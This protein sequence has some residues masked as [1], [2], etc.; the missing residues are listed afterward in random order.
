MGLQNEGCC[1]SEVVVGSGL[2]VSNFFQHSQCKKCLVKL[3]PRKLLEQEEIDAAAASVAAAPV[4]FGAAFSAVVVVVV[5]AA[6]VVFPD[7]SFSF[8]RPS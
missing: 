8:L 7:F 5:A 1:H 4:V 3:K 2:T 6:V